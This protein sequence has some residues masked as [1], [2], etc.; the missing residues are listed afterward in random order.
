MYEMVKK[1]VTV[2]ALELIST[3]DR[4]YHNTSYVKRS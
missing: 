1:D 4:I 2:S 3:G